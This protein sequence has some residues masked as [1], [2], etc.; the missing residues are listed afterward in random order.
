MNIAETL[1]YLA[2]LDGEKQT[3]F[4]NSLRD[5]LTE[6]EILALTVGIAY[7]RLL[8]VPGLQSAMKQALA[9]ELYDYFN[10]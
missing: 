7:F 8:Y 9:E 10:S 2:S 1:A 5:D 3:A 6:E 4:R